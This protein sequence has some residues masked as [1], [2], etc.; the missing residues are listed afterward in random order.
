MLGVVQ[1]HA[2]DGA[3]GHGGSRDVWKPGRP[4]RACC[5]VGATLQ[6]GQSRGYSRGAT[7]EKEASK[8]DL[9]LR[10]A[11]SPLACTLFVP[12]AG[13][14]TM[15][16]SGERPDDERPETRRRPRYILATGLYWAASG[17]IVFAAGLLLSCATSPTCTPRAAFV[18]GPILCLPALYAALLIYMGRRSLSAEPD[19]AGR[20]T[21]RPSR[22][23]DRKYWARCIVGT[24]VF[25]PTALWS[26]S[27]IFMPQIHCDTCYSWW[28]PSLYI[29][30]GVWIFS[31]I[32]LLW[33]LHPRS[34]PA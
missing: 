1:G 3:T 20:V 24:A 7:R 33:R 28:R 16:G 29:L 23:A 5:A 34:G 21:R 8:R 27:A 22:L 6:A 25:W 32:L 18:L 11:A 14:L 12:K 17:F 2:D 30:L 19:T 31:Y 10:L 15:I 26:S 4:R 13:R 9:G